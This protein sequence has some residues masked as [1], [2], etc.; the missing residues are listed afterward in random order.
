[1]STNRKREAK[2]A[3]CKSALP[4]V[5]TWNGAG[6]IDLCDNPECLTKLLET[7]N[8]TYVADGER[9]CAWKQCDRTV[10]AGYYR[11]RSTI[12]TCS[13]RC[14]TY[15]N[16]NYA[17]LVC[18]FE[19]CQKPFKG[20]RGGTRF[21][22]KTCTD[23]EFHARGVRRTGRW[24][25]LY[26]EYEQFISQHYHQGQGVK[27]ARMAA[28]AW[29]QFLDGTMIADIAE[30][31][32]RTVSQWIAWGQNVDRAVQNYMAHL[33]THMDWLIFRGLR[34]DNP[35][36]RFHR[37]REPK[38]LP[39]PYNDQEMAEIWRLLGER[40][41]PVARLAVAIAEESGLR[42]GE[43][44]NLRLSDVD[45]SGRRLFVR[46]PNKTM[47]EAW[48]PFH[49][50]TLKYLE[51]WLA[52]RDSSVKHD[53]LLHQRNRRPYN[54]ASLHYAIARIVCKTVQHK[55]VNDDGLDEWS[56]H[57]LRHTMATRLVA[58]GA[59]TATV[60]AIGRWAVAQS[61]VGYTE[62]GDSVADRAYRETMTRVVE[63]KSQPQ[64]KRSS[65]AKYVN[66]APEQHPQV[67][68]PQRV[69][70]VA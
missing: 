58:N 33:S 38:R 50:K 8:V 29:Y 12:L 57:R 62:V 16:R 52:E 54:N 48:V 15:V 34:K 36:T 14:R 21:C 68:D 56:T 7:W 46:L 30:V 13:F 41:T 22:S 39:R 44:A 4:G 42:V 31:D 64:T 37:P 65:F 25:G 66:R 27:K 20:M 19:G 61:M 63:R 60:M 45:R 70:N 47:T 11:S 1:M 51:I 40:G 26:L 35:V 9:K 10:S 32:A 3:I 67:Q 17:R 23:A 59:D 43:I 2:C 53:H 49:D 6:R 18:A 28:Q 24:R 55:T 69:T 5:E